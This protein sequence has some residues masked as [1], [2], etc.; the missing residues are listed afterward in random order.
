MKIVIIILI[1]ILFNPSLYSQVVDENAEMHK[2]KRWLKD[3]G[4]KLRFIKSHNG[5]A[6]YYNCDSIPFLRKVV[7]DTVKIW[8]EA[9]NFAMDISDVEKYMS[10]DN[11]GKTQYVKDIFSDGRVSLSG[12]HETIFI[13]RHDSLYEIESGYEEEGPKLIFHPKMFTGGKTKVKLNK[14]YNY[15]QD[16]IVLER[17]W[18]EGGVRCYTIRINNKEDGEETTYSYTF[19]QNIHFVYWENCKTKPNSVQH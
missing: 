2:T 13:S 19:D 6:V 10:Q 3:K 16:Q 17:T 18:M 11:F 12:M 15:L 4:I 8:T 14:K 5:Y 7:G 9:A 1:A